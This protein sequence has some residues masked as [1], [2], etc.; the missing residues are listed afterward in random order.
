MLISSTALSQELENLYQKDAKALYD[1]RELQRHAELFA[2]QGNQDINTFRFGD[3]YG[4][5]IKLSEFI[6]ESPV[7]LP[8]EEKAKVLELFS[9]IKDICP[10]CSTGTTVN[11]KPL[12]GLNVPDSKKPPLFSVENLQEKEDELTCITK[13]EYEQLKLTAALY[14]TQ[15]VK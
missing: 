15:K 10:D 7:D 4:R 12:I 6:I 14:E 9:K 8:K 5:P 3:A 1:M 13:T 11:G 2:Q